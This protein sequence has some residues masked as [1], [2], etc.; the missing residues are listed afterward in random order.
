MLELS[1]EELL[2]ICSNLSNRDVAKATGKTRGK[3]KAQRASILA[4]PNPYLEYLATQ[5]VRPGQWILNVQKAKELKEFNIEKVKY[6]HYLTVRLLD[7][8]KLEGSEQRF[9]ERIRNY[10]G[11]KLGD[12]DVHYFGRLRNLAERH[13]KG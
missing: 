7:E 3:I 2:L 11:S 4:N 13:G 5:K 10:D 12:L 9:I 8:G 6:W 1:E